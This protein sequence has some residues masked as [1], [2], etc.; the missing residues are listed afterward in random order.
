MTR[1]RGIRL[2]IR[3]SILT[4]LSFL[5]SLVLCAPGF[6]EVVRSDNPRDEGY[7]YLPDVPL[8]VWRDPELK[9]RGIAIAVHGL[10]MHGRVY[11]VLA[12][13]LARDGYLVVAPDLRG[14]GRWLDRQEDTSGVKV[15]YDRS[16]EDLK[17][18]VKALK[19]EYPELPLFMVG[20]SMGAGFSMRVAEAVP[21]LVDG[22]VLSS[23]AI[24]RRLYC[25]PEMVKDTITMVVNPLKQV[26][27]VPYIKKFASE[28]PDIV[29]EAVSD[30]YV[31][32]HL[33]LVEL[34]ET[35]SYIRGNINHAPRVPSR[36]PVLVMQGDCDRMLRHNAV[37]L[38][39]KKLK[40]KDQT[41][42]W[43]PGKGHVLIETA[44]IEPATLTT[45]KTWL[46]EHNTAQGVALGARSSDGSLMS[47][48]M[49]F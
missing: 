41:V 22:L 45:I 29:A 15:S 44:H 1:A 6:A 13:E 3:L 42:K 18:L 9:P 49:S 34:M 24:K 7:E 48:R 28:D 10:V 26:D 43:L 46:D 33:C 40:C 16:V 12:S 38:L 4:L 39:L 27:L 25:E 32:K 5:F 37:V 47:T 36:V 31:R 23:P 8:S 20:E 14:Y 19:H 35:A 17:G 21:G 30:P 11:D 2:N